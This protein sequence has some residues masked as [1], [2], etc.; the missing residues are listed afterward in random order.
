MFSGHRKKKLVDLPLPV[1]SLQ[2][3]KKKKTKKKPDCFWVLRTF[4]LCCLAI[5]HIFLPFPPIQMSMD[6][7]VP[8][9]K[10]SLGIF[11]SFRVNWNSMFYIHV[12]QL[13]F[14]PKQSGCIQVVYCEASCWYQ[15]HIQKFCRR[16]KVEQG[17]RHSTDHSGSTMT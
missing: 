13:F 5:C 3:K 17:Q 1:R 8:V 12:I 14:P 10:M 16:I 7:S 15:N 11:S 4:S 2:P 6:T 9:T